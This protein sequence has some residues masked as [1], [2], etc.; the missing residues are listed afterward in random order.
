M[1]ELILPLIDPADCAS[2]KVE[3]GRVIIAPG[4]PTSL[5]FLLQSGEARSSDGSRPVSGD[6]LSLCEALALE[7]YQSTVDAMTACD[8]R[9]IPLRHLEDAIRRGGRLAWPLSRSI[10]AEVTQR[11]LAG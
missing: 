4:E 6:M 3:A 10:A 8:L 11:R 9:V 5:L 7:R 2:R 1:H